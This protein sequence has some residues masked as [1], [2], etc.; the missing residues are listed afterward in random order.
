MLGDTSS[1]FLG[2]ILLSV[3]SGSL[4]RAL[5]SLLPVI[6]LDGSE[7]LAVV[8]GLT[9]GWTVERSGRKSPAGFI[10]RQIRGLPFFPPTRS[11]RKSDDD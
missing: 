2:W 4:V 11:E 8:V 10:L 7:S 6:V 9:A 5:V 1:T 3:W